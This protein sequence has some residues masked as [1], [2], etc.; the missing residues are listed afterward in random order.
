MKVCYL[1]QTHKNPEQIYR[2]VKIIKKSS[3]GAY[4]LVSHDFTSCNLDTAPLQHLQGVE[5]LSVEGGRGSFVLVQRYLDAVN[6]LLSRNIDFDWLINLSG[7][8]Y[9][10]QPLSQIEKFLAETSYDGFTEYFEVFSKQSHWSIR[11]GYSRYFY[12]YYQLLRDLPEWQK[13]LLNPLKV[14]NY[15]QPF[16]RLNFAYGMT[17]GVR[18]STPFDE[19]FICYG[20]SFFSTLSRKC[21]QYLHEFSKSNS[22]V[23]DYYKSVWNPDESFIQTVLINSRLFNLC[24]DC[25][26]YFDFS[27]TR[28][29]HPRILTQNDYPSLVQNSIHFARKFDI[30]QDSYILDLLDTRIL[31][32]LTS[33]VG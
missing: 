8:C 10:T 18:T 2:L 22:D 33:I 11:E 31:Q 25:K 23:V 3:P 9:P 26:R 12:R 30:A 5:V 29:G 24:N 17:L 6:W 16:F 4:I 28:N 21:I 15:I 32:N 27:Q 1:I 7:Q 20:G 13:E 14:I 19:N